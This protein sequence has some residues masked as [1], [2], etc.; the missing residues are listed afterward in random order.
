M[1]LLPLV[2][3]VTTAPRFTREHPPTPSSNTY[4]NHNTRIRQAGLTPSQQL[5]ALIKTTRSIL[6]S[7]CSRPLC[8]PCPWADGKY[9]NPSL[10][11]LHEHLKR[12]LFR[13]TTTPSTNFSTKKGGSLMLRG[14]TWR[15]LHHLSALVMLTFFCQILHAI[16]KAT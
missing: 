1:H 2:R 3:C 8:H 7:W 16:V 11:P 5:R 10:L 15:S 14:K 12:C 9:I 4:A 6:C 13:T